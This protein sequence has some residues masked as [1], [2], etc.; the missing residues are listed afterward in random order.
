MPFLRG[1]E[2][3]VGGEPPGRQT[4]HREEKLNLRLTLH[5]GIFFWAEKQFIIE[6]ATAFRRATA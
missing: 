1:Q 5:S 6:L 3:C 4:R 2:A